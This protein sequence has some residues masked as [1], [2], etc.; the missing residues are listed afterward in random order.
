MSAAP[1]SSSPPSASPAAA[2]PYAP[3]SS[4]RSGLSSLRS[5]V[6]VRLRAAGCVFA[7]DEAELMLRT[8]GSAGELEEMVGRRAAGEPLEHLVGWA[9]FC[10]MRVIVEPGV[11]VPRRRSEF[12]VRQAAARTRPGA[13]VVDLCCGSGALGAALAAAAAETGAAAQYPDG[14]RPGGVELHA[15]DADPVAV[16]CARR[17]VAPAGGRVHRGD[18]YAALPRRLRGHVD[19]LLANVPYVPTDS[20]RL[21][22]SEARVHE[23]RPA[24]DGG[25]DGLDVLRRVSAEAPHWLKPGGYVLVETSEAQVAAA[26]SAFEHDGLGVQVARCEELG[27]TVLIGT[28]P[29]AGS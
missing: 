7:E 19:V 20:V 17:N 3:E 25:R 21:L 16:R 4:V 24:L 11:F 23:P 8:A 5:G 6:V 15:A 14:E 28:K 13:L 10:G 12:L 1:Y 27:A 2:P 26:A 9:E 29:S 22:P 18:L